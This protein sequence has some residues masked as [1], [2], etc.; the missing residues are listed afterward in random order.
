LISTVAYQPESRQRYT[1]SRLHAQG[2]I[3]QVWLARD[4]DLGR[5]VALKELRPERA[6]HPAVW[7]RFLEEAKITGQLEHPSIVPVYELAKRTEDQK[8]FYTMRFIK[9]RTLAEAIKTYHRRREADEAGPLELR[10]L[11][12]DF[13]S[14]C[15]A[16]AY[17]HSR[18]VLHR[19]L[20]PQNVVL[21]DFGE[22]IVLDWGLA[23]VLGQAEGPVSLLPVAVA[24]EGSRDETVQGQ[25]LGTPAYMPPE[26]AE[27]RLDLL[28]QRSD[29]YGLGA[30]LYEMLTGGPPLAGE[31][32]EA[33]LRQVV[34]ESPVAP[35]QRVAATPA[36][37]E[38][39]CLKALA[40]RP[41]ER[42]GSAKELAAEVQ[43][44]LA[45]EPVTAYRDPLATRLA[46]WGRRHRTLVAGTAALLLTAVAALTAGTLLLT[47]ANRRTQEQRDLAEEN[48]RLA[49]QTVD[50]Y[51][52]Q[53]SEEQLLNVPNMQDL[54]RRLLQ[55]ALDYYQAFARQQRDDP[56]MRADLAQAYFR[57]GK[58]TEDIGSRADAWSAYQQARELYDALVQTQPQ[59]ASFRNELAKTY[60]AIGRIEAYTDRLT[61]ACA[62]FQRAIGVGEQLV[63]D[64]AD[65]PEFQ[66]DLA[67]SYYNLGTL[68]YGTDRPDKGRRSLEQAVATWER[69]VARY[70]RAEFRIGWG[71]ADSLLG[72]RLAYAGRMGEAREAFG[73]AIIQIEKALDE[74]PR[75]PEFQ[76]RLAGALDNRGTA[77]Y[78]ARQPGEARTAYKRA[79]DVSEAVVRDNRAVPQYKE[80]LIA[81]HIDRGHLF[82]STGD[83]AEAQVSF[84]QA[85]ALAKELPEGRPVSFSYASIHRGLGKLLRKQ[86]KNKDA[87]EAFQKAVEMGEKAP[88]FMDKPYSTYELACAR[89]LYSALVAE[90]KAKEEYA[91]QSVEALRQ[92]VRGGW[93]NVA[94]MDDDHDLDALRG[95]PD[96]EKLLDDLKKKQGH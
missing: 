10:E 24:P 66:R 51:L 18:R 47:Q 8:P 21:G 50:T 81:I 1:L 31:D 86:G 68:E 2:G 61:E 19:D 54:R 12:S 34:Q 23:K 87:L 14:V 70:P 28:D 57:V 20:K 7:A 59:N 11:L 74:N 17:A 64:H 43:R 85:Q 27:G 29:V 37:L 41:E 49:R 80:W 40:K 72:T 78:L 96:F 35:R 67:W 3:G 5:D 36:A 90:P 84:E 91:R 25:V 33:V 4:G 46:R 56:A 82:L 58:I 92:A 95:R 63:Q 55:S 9:G 77:C 30:I 53:V 89:A 42:Y 71:T 52:T 65:V 75:D 79:L 60:R 62:S 73:R 39:V 44:F 32:T 6:D 93:G 15:Q 83:D 69:L 88:H 22:V 94:W 76:H 13:G 38:A 48:F 16:V 26:Q 45:D